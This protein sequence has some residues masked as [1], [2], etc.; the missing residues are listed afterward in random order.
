MCSSLLGELSGCQ[1]VTDISLQT[2]TVTLLSVSHC[3]QCH[4][5]VSVT[6]LSVSHCCQCHNAVSVTMLTWPSTVTCCSST[7][8]WLNCCKPSAI[9]LLFFIITCLSMF[10]N[11]TNDKNKT[12]TTGSRLTFQSS[13]V[14][15]LLLGT[16]APPFCIQWRSTSWPALPEPFSFMFQILAVESP[17][18]HIHKHNFR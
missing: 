18:L 3:C 2:D 5:A 1:M 9:I 11:Y 8:N 13:D 14:T 10:Y 7:L 15:S 12:Q 16:S 6:L 17:E 4:N